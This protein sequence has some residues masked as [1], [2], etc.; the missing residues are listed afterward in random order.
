MTEQQSSDTENGPT[1]NAQPPLFMTLTDVAI[2]LRVST[3]QV[4]RLLSSGRMYP[5]D[6]SLGGKRGRRWRRDRFE[7]WVRANCPR[8]RAWQAFTAAPSSVALAQ[9]MDSPSLA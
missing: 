5:A 4:R 9:R 2:E 3:R 6:V 8:A 1:D 7:E